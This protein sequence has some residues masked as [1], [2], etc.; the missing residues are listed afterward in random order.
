MV[1]FGL[2]KTGLGRYE[3]KETEKQRTNAASFLV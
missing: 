1:E 3:G 2:K